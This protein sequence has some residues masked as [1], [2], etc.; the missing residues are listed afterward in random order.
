MLRELRVDSADAP[1]FTVSSEHVT[2]VMVLN[3][4]ERIPGEIKPLRR[5]INLLYSLAVSMQIQISIQR[6]YVWLNYS[7][8]V[9]RLII[10]DLVS[11]TPV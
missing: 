10:I 4:A 8:T 3:L 5:M 6:I 2:F 11:V 1:G 9:A 7:V